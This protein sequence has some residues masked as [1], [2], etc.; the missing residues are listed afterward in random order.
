MAL[1]RISFLILVLSINA[2]SS[3]ADIDLNNERHVKKALVG[4]W[5]NTYMEVRGSRIEIPDAQKTTTVFNS[6]GTSSSKAKGGVIE[7]KSEW[8]YDPGR[9]RLLMGAGENKSEERIY[10]LTKNELILVTYLSVNDQIM[11]S[12]VLTY[13]R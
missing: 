12:T 11:D 8:S 10:K 5:T 7:T 4:E 13:K 3:S 1:V 6:D 2:C 9:K